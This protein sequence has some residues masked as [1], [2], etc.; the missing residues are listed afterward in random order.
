M[1]LVRCDSDNATCSEKSMAILPPKHDKP[2]HIFGE[3]SQSSRGKKHVEQ[4][5]NTFHSS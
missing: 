5:R 2:Y 3:A 1:E 4:N